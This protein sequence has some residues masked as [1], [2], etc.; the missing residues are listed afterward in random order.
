M[1]DTII[2]FI[3]AGNMASS[4]IGGLINKG[5]SAA[6]ILACDPSQDQLDRLKESVRSIGNNRDIRHSDG[7]QLGLYSDS[8]KISTAEVV[9][10]AVKPQILKM[11]ALDIAPK[12]KPGAMVISIAAGISM[13]SLGSWLGDCAIVRCMPNTPALIQQGASGLYANGATTEDQ[14]Q[15]AQDILSAVG[16]AYWVE[17]EHLI[18][19]VTAVSG[20][21]PAYFFLFTELMTEIAVEMGLSQQVAE[22][23][24]V[25]TCLGAGQLAD[26]STDSL[27]TLRQKVTSPGGTTEAAL[28]RFQSDNLKQLIRNAMQDCA[29]RAQGMANEF[30]D[31]E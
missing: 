26:Q 11:V 17:S 8:A 18:D 20:S 29:D 1:T 13:K 25:Q 14:K 22:A 3:G 21:G 9:I 12:L 5:Y 10:L 31:S 7:D 30:G 2:G 6:N 15:I 4:L 19:V 28:N 23:L 24:S 27:S 16:I